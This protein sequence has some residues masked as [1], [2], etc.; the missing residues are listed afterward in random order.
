MRTPIDLRSLHAFVTVARESNVSRAAEALHLTQ[1]A[2]SLQLKRLATETG[3]TLFH[4]T[5]KGVELTRDGAA[6]L[7]KAEQVLAALEDF[8]QTAHRMTG[9]VRGALR[10]GTVIDPDFIRL[11]QFLSA[12]A[13]AAPELRTQLAHGMSGDVPVRLAR[14]EID[15]GYFLGDLDEETAAPGAAPQFHH[16][17]LTRFRYRVIAPAGWEQRTAGRDWKALAELPWIGTPP[18]SVH[19]RLLNRLFSGLGVTQNQ[20]AVVDQEPSMLAM[21]RSGGGLSLCRESVAL[22]E[23]QIHGLVVVEDAALEVTLGLVTLASRKG[24]PAIELGF[25]VIRK[26]W[27]LGA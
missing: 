2:I 12:M 22:N 15:L 8:R 13:Q 11:G 5:S 17:A 18:A 1:P 14:G 6:L 23:K 27:N 21:V 3:L 20:V 24:E 19:H 16:R 10:V 26:I 25:D 4:R 9:T 7:V